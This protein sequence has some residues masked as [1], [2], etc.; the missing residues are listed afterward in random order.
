MSLNRGDHTDAANDVRTAQ[1]LLKDFGF[2]R[3]FDGVPIHHFNRLWFK[4]FLN[5]AGQISV[6]GYTLKDRYFDIDPG[7][8]NG[9][10]ID[11]NLPLGGN[12]HGVP[13]IHANAAQMRQ[14]ENRDRRLYACAMS[15]IVFTCYLYNELETLF[16][17]NGRS[18]CMYILQVGTLPFQPHEK[19]KME[20]DWQAMSILTLRLKVT[21]TMIGMWYNEVMVKSADFEPEKTYDDCR[22]K[23]LEGL[24]PQLSAEVDAEYA[25]PNP[26]YR[27]P[28]RYVFPHPLTGQIHPYAGQPDCFKM[29]Q[30]F[31]KVFVRKLDAGLIRAPAA[32]M[33]NEADLL[34]LPADQNWDDWN[35]WNNPEIYDEHGYFVGRGGKGRGGYGYGRGKGRGHQ[36]GG[37]GK[38]K[39]GKGKGGGQRIEFDDKTRC[40]QCGGLGHIF[41]FTRDGVTYTCPTRTQISR[42]ILDAIVYPHIAPQR[43]NEAAE[44]E[45]VEKG[46]KARSTQR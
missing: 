29:M 41:R 10:I 22:V 32:N 45:E 1:N 31:T 35:D 12:Y 5:A 6:D 21:P 13:Q 14:K 8:N 43:A 36:G 28:P 20:A 18:A 38:G 16:A 42:E 23:F 19:A 17:N 24:P 34:P 26:E 3:K 15:H 2:D 44:I 37:K 33:A 30:D 7:A 11:P 25:R 27:F 40:Y 9:P 39:G 46:K 4:P